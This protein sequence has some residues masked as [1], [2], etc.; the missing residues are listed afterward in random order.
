MG[1]W[2][3]QSCIQSLNIPFH[4]PWESKHEPSPKN[5]KT[6]FFFQKHQP[7]TRPPPGR[8]P[9]EIWRLV[10]GGGAFLILQCWFNLFGH[11]H[12]AVFF[13]FEILTIGTGILLDRF[14]CQHI[15]LVNS[16]LCGPHC[17]ASRWRS[18]LA[19]FLFLQ[20]CY[21]RPICIVQITP[22]VDPNYSVDNVISKLNGHVLTNIKKSKN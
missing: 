16:C 15:F 9:D 4:V 3:V 6:T 22:D 14:W 20:Y 18:S 17:G 13:F 5:Q 7:L 12:V 1:H 2:V 8:A 11:I 21:C 10:H 19:P